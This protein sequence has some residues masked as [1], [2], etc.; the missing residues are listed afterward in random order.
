MAR[1]PGIN[2]KFFNGSNQYIGFSDR[3][4]GGI[5]ANPTAVYAHKYIGDEF[6]ERI[7]VTKNLTISNSN[8]CLEKTQVGNEKRVM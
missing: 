8:S 6:I 4:F 2:Y 5:E 1:L 3:Y 7:E